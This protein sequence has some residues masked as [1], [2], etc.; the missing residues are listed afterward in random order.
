MEAISQLG[1]FLQYGSF[2]LLAIVLVVIFFYAKDALKQQG[3]MAAAERAASSAREERA[4]KEREKSVEALT[5]LVKVLSAMN[6]RLEAHATDTRTRHNHIDA[7]LADITAKLDRN[8][9]DI[10]G[11]RNSGG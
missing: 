6:E 10:M 1:A 9:E 7:E 5:E 4:C 8:R 2:G 11:R 3:V